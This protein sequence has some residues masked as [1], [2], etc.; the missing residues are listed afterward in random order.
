MPPYF[1]P[2]VLL[3]ICKANLK[4]R[5]MFCSVKRQR[6]ALSWVCARYAQLTA[7]LWPGLPTS[8]LGWSTQHSAAVWRSQPSAAGTSTCIQQHLAEIRA[9]V[10]EAALAKP[11]SK[12]TSDLGRAALCSQQHL[13]ALWKAPQ[14]V[15]PHLRPRRLERCP[16]CFTRVAH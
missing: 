14:G 1:W 9:W 6:C 16:G 2:C 12:G 15:H 8:W 11:C 4:L 5:S 13:Q 3:I 7:L 10:L